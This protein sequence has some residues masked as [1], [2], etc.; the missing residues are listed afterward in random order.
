MHLRKGHPWKP[1]EAIPRHVFKE[2]PLRG[3]HTTKY[4]PRRTFDAPWLTDTWLPREEIP[5]YIRSEPL[6]RGVRRTKYLPRR[7]VGML[8]P[9]E[10][11]G[12]SPAAM[13]VMTAVAVAVPL[14]A[15]GGLATAIY[16]AVK[17]KKKIRNYGI[18]ASAVGFVTPPIL[19][20]YAVR[21]A[22]Q[23]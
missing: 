7:T 2:P 11:S 20:G 22:A 4:M 21:K 9:K 5:S 6:G 3:T 19:V 10:L 18:A 1:T 12:I 23:G 13:G 15:W 14:L 8:L 16:G 17:N